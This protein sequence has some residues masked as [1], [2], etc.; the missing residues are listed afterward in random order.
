[1][2]QS[3]TSSRGSAGRR[4]CRDRGALPLKL[5]H[6]GRLAAPRI[7]CSS[8]LPIRA[9]LACSEALSE[10]TVRSIVVVDDEERLSLLEQL[11]P[12]GNRHGCRHRRE[13]MKLF[14]AWVLSNDAR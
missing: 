11:V 4:T 3:W 7:P 12:A 14:R 8:P 1:M 10:A 2:Y 6:L 9:R 5:D 13:E